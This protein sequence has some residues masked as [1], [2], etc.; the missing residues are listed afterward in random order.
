MLRSKLIAFSCFCAIALSFIAQADSTD[1]VFWRYWQQQMSAKK[2]TGDF[3]QEKH[4]SVL[5]KPLISKG[6][7]KVTNDKIDWVITAPVAKHFVFDQNGVIDQSKSVSQTDAMGN[8][9]ALKQFSAIFR[10]LFTGNKEQL[11]QF[12]SISVK[13]LNEHKWV[14][15][16]RPK[17]ALLRKGLDNVELI[18]NQLVEVIHVTETNGDKTLIKLL[19]VQTH[20]YQDRKSG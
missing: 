14:L 15:D 16:L 11:Q 19:N 10:P 13:K 8:N 18:I 9:Q 17:D 20:T 1:D 7:F 12:F 6:S 4:I 2:L 5:S 3:L